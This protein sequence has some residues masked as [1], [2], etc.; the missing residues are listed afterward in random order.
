M[1]VAPILEEW[2][3][4]REDYKKLEC[5]NVE[6]LKK[7]KELNGAQQ[8]CLKHIQHQRYRMQMMAKTLRKLKKNKESSE[9]IK[10][11]E[12]NLLKR[13]AELQTIEE[14]LPKK[15]SVYLKL[16]LG[17]ID[18]SF[19]SKDEKFKYKDD[20]EK[21]KLINHVIAVVAN[22]AMLY[23]SCRAIEI[24]YLGFLVW[25]YCTI[26]IKEAIL[27]ANGSRIKGWWRLHHILSTISSGILLIWPE[28]EPWRQ[29]REQFIWY[30]LYSCFVTYLQ[31]KYQRG[32]LYRL[33][34]LGERD[35][36]DIT[37]EGF[38]SWMWRGLT[39]LL[40]FLFIGYLFQLIHAV[41]LYKLSYHPEA[42]WQV[43]TTSILFFVFFLGNTVTTILVVP[44]KI[45]QKV[46]FSYKVMTRRV[47][48]V[49][50]DTVR[51]GGRITTNGIQK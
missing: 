49:L 11:M 14:R 48:N 44:D 40:P 30:N 15:G 5:A 46:M 17:D 36:M 43:L 23:T 7:L 10:E 38:H 22:V 24:L 9:K 37:I 45:K 18:V 31:F 28:N 42:T 39:F 20:Y 50:S 35:N 19:L 29:F 47:Y 21:F 41:V 16:I 25:Y 1:E 8:Q 6:Y 33:K 13:E 26:T 27:R 51:T 34:A 4:L 12:D 3:E 32:A 2:E